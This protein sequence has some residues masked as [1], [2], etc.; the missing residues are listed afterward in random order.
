MSSWPEGRTQ[1]I[2]D[3]LVSESQTLYPVLFRTEV[4][5]GT[6]VSHLKTRPKWKQRRTWRRWVWKEVIGGYSIRLPLFLS[7]GRLRGS[8]CVR[9]S[10]PGHCQLSLVYWDTSS[11]IHQNLQLH[12]MDSENNETP[13]TTLEHKTCVW[14]SVQHPGVWLSE[15]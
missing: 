14:A 8:L 10:G 11:S 2:R 12:T 9:W 13:S 4:N 5:G 7:T 3:T 6:G 15:S 1:P